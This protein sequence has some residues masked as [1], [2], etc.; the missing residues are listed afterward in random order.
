MDNQT[1]DLLNWQ[2]PASRR[3]D[4]ITSHE[5]ATTAEMRASEG[6]MLVLHNLR[7]R[8]MSDFDL[9]AVTG[10]IATSI[11]KRRGEARDAGLVRALRNADGELIKGK[12][13]MGSNVIMWEITEAGIQYYSERAGA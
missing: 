8:P 7:V 5:A 10:W 6:R 9:A 2:A 11:G 4:P 13:P 1:M 12:S 3:T